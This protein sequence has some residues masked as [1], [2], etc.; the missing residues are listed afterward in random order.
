MN[1]RSHHAVWTNLSAVPPVFS[2]GILSVLWS[3]TAGH[4][5]LSFSA[6]CNRQRPTAPYSMPWS[7]QSTC[8]SSCRGIRLKELPV[9]WHVPKLPW[10]TQCLFGAHFS[11][12]LSQALS[13]YLY[14]VFAL[15][16]VDYY[17]QEIIEHIQWA[18]FIFKIFI[19]LVR[20]ICNTKISK[21]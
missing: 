17:H 8:C 18:L 15:W 3:R 2:G 19:L 4:W 21:P 11:C 1:L 12:H 13:V 20:F 6:T 5:L 16:Y 10:L 9:A 14:L 7:Q